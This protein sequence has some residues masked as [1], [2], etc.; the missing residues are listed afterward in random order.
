MLRV[1]HHNGEISPRD[2]P[3]AN[4]RPTHRV[5][6]QHEG[7][8]VPAIKASTFYS[9][10]LTVLFRS[11]VIFLISSAISVDLDH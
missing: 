4:T 1:Q 5:L 9:D 10:E 8:S 3:V 2:T 11:F 6:Q 7:V